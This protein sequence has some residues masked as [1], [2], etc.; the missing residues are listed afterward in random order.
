[1]TGRYKSENSESRAFERYEMGFK[2]IVDGSTPEGRQFTEET[3][4]QDISGEG[5]KFSTQLPTNYFAGQT[6]A[7]TIYLPAA[8]NVRANM[9]TQGRVI[10]VETRKARGPASNGP[11]RYVA[12]RLDTPLQFE[13]AADD[14]AQ[15][16]G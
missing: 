10:R 2:L 12:V 11:G 13:T 9:S 8:G 15:V 4:L 3:I 6:I 5:A 7:M 16:D 1:M 14:Q